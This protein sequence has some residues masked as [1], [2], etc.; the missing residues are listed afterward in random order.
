MLH[1]ICIK[2]KYDPPHD[3]EF[4]HHH[5]DHSIAQHYI[6]PIA[7]KHK[8]TSASFV[9]VWDFPNNSLY[10]TMGKWTRQKMSL[11]VAFD[12]WGGIWAAN[13]M[14]VSL[15]CLFHSTVCSLT[16]ITNY[17]RVA[18]HSTDRIEVVCEREE[19]G[20]GSNKM[21]NTENR[22]NRRWHGET[23][24]TYLSLYRIIQHSAPSQ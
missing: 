16:Q 10:K 14:S 2:S 15:S 5:R 23:E 12:H 19:E 3:K 18:Q 11:P 9:S 13:W 4:H 6:F 22:T 8:E 24:Q 21:T 20:E 1:V 17:L 7:C